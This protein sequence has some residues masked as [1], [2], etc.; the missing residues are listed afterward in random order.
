MSSANATSNALV[1]EAVRELRVAEPDLG[2][3]PLLAKLREQQPGLGACTKDVRKALT[4]LKAQESSA[5]ARA[6]ALQPTAVDDVPLAEQEGSPPN[7][8]LSLA[9]VGPVGLPSSEVEN[10]WGNKC[11]P[12]RARKPAAATPHD[13]PSFLAASSPPCD[14]SRARV[15]SPLALLLCASRVRSDTSL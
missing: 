12:S 5:A 11:H 3:K 8:A 2:L 9:C 1:L 14:A 15:M 10:E 6:A 4:A 7:A 13:P